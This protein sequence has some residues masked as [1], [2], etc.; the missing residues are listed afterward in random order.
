MLSTGSATAARA[1]LCPSLVEGIA[2]LPDGDLS[3]HSITEEP[4]PLRGG[5][6]CWLICVLDQHLASSLCKVSAN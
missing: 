5:Q 6:Y 1:K 4:K 3:L 2:Y